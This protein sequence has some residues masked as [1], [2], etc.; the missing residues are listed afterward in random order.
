MVQL[1]ELAVENL[2]RCLHQ[3]PLLF[4]SPTHVREAHFVLDTHR[5]RY[6]IDLG[7]DGSEQDELSFEEAGPRQKRSDRSN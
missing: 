4:G 6:N 5:I 7:D 2:G 3:S 1:E